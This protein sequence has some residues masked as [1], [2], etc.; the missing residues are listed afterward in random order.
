MASFKAVLGE[1]TMRVVHE[2]P[3]RLKNFYV[4]WSMEIKL[5]IFLKQQNG[6]V[7]YNVIYQTRGSV[8]R[9]ID[10]H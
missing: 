8:F 4:F 6:S 1:F 3:Q 7:M 9:Q 5:F 10:E 2:A